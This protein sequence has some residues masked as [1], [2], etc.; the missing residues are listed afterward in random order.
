MTHATTR[1][2]T[3]VGTANVFTPI[4][5]DITLPAGGPFI[6][7]QVFVNAIMQIPREDEGI[8]GRLRL[9]SLQGDLEPNPAPALYPLTGINAI[10]GA[11]IPVIE[12]S[13]MFYPVNWTAAGKSTLRLEGALDEDN[14]GNV[15]LATGIIFGD[16]IPAKVPMLFTDRLSANKPGSGES[17][18]GSITLSQRA[19][20]ITGVLGIFSKATALT[21]QQANIGFF[22]LTS[23]SNKIQPADF[24]M[25]NAH[26]GML[27][28]A[29]GAAAPN[30]YDYI[31]VDIP[32]EN[33]AIIDIAV[34]TFLAS[35]AGVEVA[36][37][38]AYE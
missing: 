21:A 28:S 32:I 33:G 18:I 7:S 24:P 38:L 10:A 27:G 14:T 1:L 36:V 25:T 11:T 6:I 2:G 3:L 22:T 4:G 26:S 23:A 20:K 17:P 15:S 9:T 31:P 16:E 35:T 5:L 37:Y 12:S 13:T 8:S 34:T 19:T 30:R 29:A